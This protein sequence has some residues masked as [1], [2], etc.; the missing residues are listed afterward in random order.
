MQIPQDR[1]VMT[2]LK[3][4]E[5]HGHCENQTCGFLKQ[6]KREFHKRANI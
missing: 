6:K 3:A 4:D 5:K 2:P 1:P